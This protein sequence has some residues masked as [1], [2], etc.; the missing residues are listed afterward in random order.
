MWC[1]HASS[2]QKQP[3]FWLGSCWDVQRVV[4]AQP[5]F[6]ACM[7]PARGLS[8]PCPLAALTLLL[9]LSSK[10][11]P[12]RSF[13]N[14]GTLIRCWM[15]CSRWACWRGAGWT[16]WAET[17]WLILFKFPFLE[18]ASA[19]VCAF[20]S[21]TLV[22]AGHSL[23]QDG[24]HYYAA[25]MVA[26]NWKVRMFH[27]RKAVNFCS[28]QQMHVR[29][30]WVGPELEGGF[31]AQ[32]SLFNHHTHCTSGIE[33][34]LLLSFPAICAHTLWAAPGLA[35]RALYFSPECSTGRQALLCSFCFSWLLFFQ[36]FFL[37]LV[38][39]LLFVTRGCFLHCV[40]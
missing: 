27:I 4:E 36:A 20:R 22:S 38:P 6:C 13:L 14:R 19:L 12:H 7:A 15:L 30:G 23:L 1:A 34:L 3:G 33:D 18:D 39:Q 32:W 21:V 29:C 24:Q 8:N 9:S 11:G 31:L 5:P 35:V 16:C 25:K 28:F 26:F 10:K 2:F 40:F 37:L 17:D